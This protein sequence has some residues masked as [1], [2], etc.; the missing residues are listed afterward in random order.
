MES[1]VSGR[2][3]IVNLREERVDPREHLSDRW[4]TLEVATVPP[5]DELHF[6]AGEVEHATYILRGSGTARTSSEEIEL[7]PGLGITLPKG[8]A[9]TYR[10]LEE[11]LEVFHVALETA[12]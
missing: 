9:A 2:A 10:A 4:R 12:F 11:P 6:E 8:T 1:A 3:T 5:G 7:R